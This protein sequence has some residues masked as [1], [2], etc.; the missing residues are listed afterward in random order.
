MKR[1]PQNTYEAAR[2]L[3]WATLQERDPARVAS[4]GL[5][6][7]DETGA[8]IRVPFLA[9]CYFVDVQSRKVF[10][11]NGSEVYP[12]LS[13]LLLHYLAGVDETPLAGE[14]I[15]FRE[16]EGGDAYFGS[17]NDRT[18]IPLKKAFGHRPELLPPAAAPLAAEPLEFGDV[19]LRVPVFPKVPLAVVLWRGDSEFPPEANVLFDKT[20]NSILRTE[21]LAICGALTVSKLRKNAEKIPS[22]G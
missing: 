15:S 1:P 20:A 16:F 10:F 7:V 13:V 18:L 12:F 22:S 4:H 6:E 2:E 14:W 8:R 5:V 3:A 17:F 19:G 11:E 21:D 9:E